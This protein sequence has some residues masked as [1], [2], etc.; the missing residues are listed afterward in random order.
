[1]YGNSKSKPPL[2]QKSKVTNAELERVM[3]SPQDNEADHD[4]RPTEMSPPDAHKAK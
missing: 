1:M 3:T 2:N 4:D